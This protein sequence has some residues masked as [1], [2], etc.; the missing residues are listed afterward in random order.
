MIFSDTALYQGILQDIDFLLFGE[1]TGSSA[2]A[3]ADKTRNVNRHLD[4]VVALILQ[5]DGRWQWDDTNNTNL[6]IGTTT[7]V[8]SQQDY[9]ITG[10]TFLDVL[11]VEVLDSSGNYNLLTPID[12][13]EVT[14]QALSEFQKTAG[15]PRYYDKVG[16]SIFLYPKP[17]TSLVTAS[18][19][20]KVYF[21]RGASYFAATDTTKVPGFAAPF[22]RIL[23][24]GA[25]L[26][27]AY[28]NDMANKIRVL[29]PQLLKLQTAL[30]TFYSQRS[31]DENV[32]MKL[33]RTS[34]GDEDDGGFVR[35]KVAF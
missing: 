15:M 6:P 32:R 27:Y 19:G 20:L 7:L 11:R 28:A 22:H 29:E 31:R 1:S 33:H 8:D 26:D 3:T 34:Y 25:A 5:S 13:S 23:S 10:A 17:S 18:A 2:Y 12:Q 24:V 35:D 4:D 9:S 16:D 21:Q 14:D 30:A